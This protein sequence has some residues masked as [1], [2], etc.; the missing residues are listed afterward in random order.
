MDDE[1]TA[2]L[3]EQTLEFC[4]SFVENDMLFLYVYTRAAEALD[5]NL[6][7]YDGDPVDYRGHTYNMTGICDRRRVSVYNDLLNAAVA[8]CRTQAKSLAMLF[9]SLAGSQ[10]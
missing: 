4:K 1:T 8:S 10:V 6:K 2:R 3:D 7:V 5:G 9:H